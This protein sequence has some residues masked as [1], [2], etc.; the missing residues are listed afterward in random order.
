MNYKIIT[1]L[2][3]GFSCLFFVLAIY[4][5]IKNSFPFSDNKLLNSE[6]YFKGF[7]ILSS[8]CTII[9]IA[10]AL[11]SQDSISTNDWLKTFAGASSLL[12]GIVIFMKDEANL[13]ALALT[14]LSGIL[15][16]T[17]FDTK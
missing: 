14:T 7:M 2:L 16:A 3:L 13:Y 8:I 12:A 5:N 1:Y 4:I 10:L 6:T 15:V 9:S 11:K 17:S